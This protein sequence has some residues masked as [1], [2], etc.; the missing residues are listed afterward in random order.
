MKILITADAVGGVWTYALELI[1]AL[2]EHQFALA[3]MGPRMTNEQRAEAKAL[4]NLKLFES[5]YALEWMD[6]PWEQVDRSSEWLLGVAAEFRPDLVHLNGYSHA[7]LHFEA[8]VVVVAHSCVLSWW[9]AVKKTTA[10]AQ[11]NEYRRRVAAGLHAANLVVAPTEAMLNSLRINYDFRGDAR[12]IPN[13][14]DAKLFTARA[15]V[16]NIVAVGRVWDD[17]K[18]LAALDAVAPRV[19]WPI[20]IIGETSHPN[21]SVAQ[22]RNAR[23]FGVLGAGELREHLAVSSIYV[24]PARYEP[25]GLSPLEAGLAGCA[26]VLG[27]IPSLRE[28]WGDAAFFVEPDDRPGLEAALNKLIRDDQLRADLARKARARAEEYSPPRMIEGYLRAYSD[29]CRQKQSKAAA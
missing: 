10:P 12:V 18:N 14:R 28:V 16:A 4:P 17:A 8:P 9:Q 2:S 25:F 22:L 19:R 11:Y 23:S 7:T 6:G 27:D 5:T 15:K 1:G 24:L 29:C 3:V 20:E 13:A 26:L 21:G